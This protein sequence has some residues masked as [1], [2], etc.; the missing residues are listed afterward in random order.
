MLSVSLICS[1]KVNVKLHLPQQQQQQQ[2]QA[3][4]VT[5]TEFG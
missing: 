1:Q 5:L 3:H 2:Q 4:K